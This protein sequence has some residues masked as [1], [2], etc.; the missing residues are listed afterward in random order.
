MTSFLDKVRASSEVSRRS[1]VKASAAASAVLAAGAMAGCANKVEMADTGA[2]AGN[3]NTSE[4]DYGRDLT[5]GTWVSAACWHNCGGRCMNKVLVQDGV[6]VRQKSDDTH[7]DSADY[8][9]Q[10]GC[11]RGR[12]QRMQVFGADR[13]KYPMKR[14]SW[15]PDNPNGHLRGKDEWER[16][17]WDEAF[18]YVGDQL[19]RAYDTYGPR[20]V[21]AHS[22]SYVSYNAMRPL[23]ALGGYVSIT[24]TT[25]MG[26]YNLD[27]TK[28]GLP[29]KDGGA[30][31]ANDRYDM[32]NAETIVLQGCNPAWASAGSTCLNFL[33][34]KAAGVSFVVIAPSY[35]ATAQLLNA[36]WIPLRA[37]TDTAFMIAVAY[38]MIKLDEELGNIVD[39]DFLNTYCVGFDA[40]HMPADAT[41]DENFKDYLLGVYD[42]TP[43]TAEWASEICG[44]PVEDI[45]WYAEAVGKEHKVMLLHS[46]SFARCHDSEDVPQMFMTL[47]AMGGHFGKSGHACG[48]AYYAQAGNGGPALVA[49]GMANVPPIENGVD[50]LVVGPILWKSMLEKKYPFVGNICGVTQPR[51][52]RDLDIHVIFWEHTARLQTT[53][54]I[55]RGIEAHRAVDFVFCNAQ[56]L[57]TQAKYSDIVLPVTTEWERPGR[58]GQLSNRETLLIYSQVIEPLFEAKTDQEIGRGIAEACGLNPD[59]V[60]PLSE[61]QQFM[62][63]ILGATVT[64]GAEMVPLVT[65]TADDL[66]AWEC[67]GEPQEGKVSLA[68]FME[69][70]SYQ[71]ERSAGDEHSFIAYADF[72]ADPVANPLP[73]NSGKF[74]IYCQWK[75]DT[76]DSLGFS[77]NFKPYPS[78]HPAV[79]GWE[80]RSDEYPYVAYNP[81]YYRRSHSV[82]DNVTWLREAWPNPVFISAKDAADKGIQTGD[83]VVIYNAYG[84]IVRT[85]SVLQTLMPGMVGIPHG[86]WVNLDENEEYDLGGADNVL[87]GPSVSGMGVSGYNNYNCNFEK[88]TGEA[89]VP[90]CEQPQRI[91]EL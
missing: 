36:R 15:S 71:V 45:R 30:A 70:G 38:E 79:E 68:E 33:N 58:F 76:L 48:T 12:S 52:E 88:Y 91:I 5:E 46:Y 54:D 62:N 51:E 1:F 6:V 85:A 2:S 80:T 83:D 55:L 57:T 74:E 67:E 72:V 59:E 43:K 49:S 86:A 66:A 18:K 77:D 24:D 75:K 81:H 50:D 89:L 25:S 28:L 69:R 11:V 10:R 37:G 35:N 73:S 82:Y 17:S 21:L 31:S 61:K 44:T 7:E 56:F 34:A 3:E 64:D 14:K 19:R 40:D 4:T 53:P 8:P 16:I 32:L 47:G 22:G 13:L 90:D 65:V 78:Y 26:T 20:S 42:G 27:T 9:Q 39:W 87:C 60:Y 63:E 84:K 29:S 23:L 41:T